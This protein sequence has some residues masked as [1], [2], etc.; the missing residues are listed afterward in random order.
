MGRKNE[1]ARK[2]FR[3]NGKLF[4]FGKKSYKK[5]AQIYCNL[6]NCY[7]T[8]RDIKEKKCNFKRCVHRREI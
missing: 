6:H 1:N 4:L 5:K 3:G 8:K 7:L 2:I